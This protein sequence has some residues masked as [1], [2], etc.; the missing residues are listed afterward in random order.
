MLRNNERRQVVTRRLVSAAQKPDLAVSA[1]YS[2][3]LQIAGM[4]G[5]NPTSPD[6]EHPA[7]TLERAAGFKRKTSWVPPCR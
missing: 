2:D 1:A 3:H 5:S 4:V 6:A 7:P